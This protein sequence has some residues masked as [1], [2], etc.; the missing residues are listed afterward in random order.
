MHEADGYARR[1]GPVSEGIG[2]GVTG[3]DEG[4]RD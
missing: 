1:L 4:W 3:T 2:L